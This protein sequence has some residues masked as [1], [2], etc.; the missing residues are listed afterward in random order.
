ML[1][2]HIATPAGKFARCT[3]CRT[4]PRHVAHHGRTLRETMERDIPALRHS[5]ECRC[6]RS[7]G[8]HASLQGAEA[9]WGVLHAQIPMHLPAATPITKAAARRRPPQERARG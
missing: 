3:T 9:D 7:T 2:I 6:G 1:Q 8:L 5:L 4:E